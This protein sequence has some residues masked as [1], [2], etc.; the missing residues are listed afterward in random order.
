M[1]TNFSIVIDIEQKASVLD[2]ELFS[3]FNIGADGR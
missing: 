1:L 3:E 2:S